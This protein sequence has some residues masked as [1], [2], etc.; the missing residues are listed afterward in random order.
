M[1]Y[2]LIFLLTL[3]L[4]IFS[5][6][7]IN[8]KLEVGESIRVIPGFFNLTNVHNYGFAFGVLSDR[9]PGLKILIALVATFFLAW[10]LFWCFLKHRSALVHL[11]AT[12]IVSGGLGNIYDR[13]RY[14]YVRDFLDFYIS[15]YHWP[16]FNFADV[17][18]SVGVIIFL[19]VDLFKKLRN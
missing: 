11:A 17:W 16:A 10:F 1:K 7:L 8:Q 19:Y 13:I 5:K 4:D 15:N 9:S 12:L 3:T 18:I 6:N 14:G 2:L